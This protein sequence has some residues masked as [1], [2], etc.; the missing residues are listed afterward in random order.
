[1]KRF[2]VLLAALLAFA[3]TAK[4]QEPRSYTE[5]AISVVT[6]VKIM[7]GQFDN[8]MNYLD[9]TY[10]SVMEAQKKA[11][12]ILDYAIYDASPRTPEDAD[13]YLVVVYPS[14]ASFDGLDDKTEPLMSKVTGL[15]RAAANAASADRGKMRTILGSEIVR[16]LKLK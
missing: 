1:M 12:I 13:L 2:L 14:M 8:Y 5:G 16:E 9:Q 10:K 6:S 11:G 3:I 4:A 15:N 7:D